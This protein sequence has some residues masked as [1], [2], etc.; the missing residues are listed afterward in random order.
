MTVTFQQFP[1]GSPS[2]P[3]PRSGCLPLV[4]GLVI[5]AAVVALALA[6]TGAIS[7]AD[8]TPEEEAYLL[9][10]TVDMDE[11]LAVRAGH[12][13]CDVVST[14]S[15]R[16]AK[17]WLAGV[18]DLSRLGAVKA[19]P[20]PLSAPEANAVVNAAVAHLCR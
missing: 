7:G 2:A 10:L 1:P 12:A 16:Y 20:N 13:A 11:D 19:N 6:L 4:G 17:E 18:D 9:A 5:A 15:E 14:S 8:R 3:R